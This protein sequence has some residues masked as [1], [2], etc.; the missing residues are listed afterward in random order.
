MYIIQIFN[1]SSEHVLLS[2]HL[3]SKADVCALLSCFLNFGHPCCEIFVAK[4]SVTFPWLTFKIMNIITAYCLKEVSKLGGG[5]EKKAIYEWLTH[6]WPL[7]QSPSGINPKGLISILANTILS[8]VSQANGF[9]PFA[10]LYY[11]YCRH[12]K[13]NKF[14]R[15][16]RI[17]STRSEMNW[18]C[19]RC[20]ERSGQMFRFYKKIQDVLDHC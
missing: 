19:A 7:I 12:N 13:I 5:R 3:W 18:S 9:F 1:L 16:G 2:V 20:I 15:S 14:W 6:K 10:P 11:D 8:Y 17:D 4:S